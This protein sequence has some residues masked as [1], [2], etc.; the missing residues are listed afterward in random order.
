MSNEIKAYPKWLFWMEVF[1]ILGVYIGI[2]GS[3]NRYFFYDILSGYDIFVYVFLIIIGLAF[4]FFLIT[5]ATGTYY[6]KKRETYDNY[7]KKIDILKSKGKYCSTLKY[8]ISLIVGF[9]FFASVLGISAIIALKSKNEIFMIV[10]I[11]FILGLLG[12]IMS[13][14]NGSFYSLLSKKRKKKESIAD[15]TKGAEVNPVENGIAIP[16]NKN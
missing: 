14:R 10:S 6:N 5:L 16:D 3:F 11:I 9:A 2:L 7:I 1:V 8:T 12:F 15:N 13:V 4:V